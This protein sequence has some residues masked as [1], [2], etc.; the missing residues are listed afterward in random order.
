MKWEKIGTAGSS[1]GSGVTFYKGTVE[2]GQ[3]LAFKS[4]DKWGA[5]LLAEKINGLKPAPVKPVAQ[6]APAAPKKAFPVGEFRNLQ[7][8][9]S[10]SGKWN[11][12]RLAKE[13]LRQESL[14]LDTD[15]TP[16]DIVV[17]RTTALLKHLQAMPDGP[18]LKTE[19]AELSILKA[20]NK[21]GLSSEAF[22]SLF[23][24]VIALRRRIAF[25][26]PLLDF[27]R[28]AFLKHNGAP[29]RSRRSP[30][31]IRQAHL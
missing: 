17:R 9:I 27:E 11:R 24:K 18:A 4:V 8:Q 13:V 25:Q 15:K 20:E 14:I 28:I 3:T 23:T 2:A 12:E 7:Q 21:P 5:I 19:E 26:N 16:V 10:E 6:N 29:R 31:L 30:R 1:P 22:Q